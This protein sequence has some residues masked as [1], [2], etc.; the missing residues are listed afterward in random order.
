VEDWVAELERGR[1]DAAWDLFLDRYRRLIFAAIRHYAQDYDDVMDVFARACE[2]LRADNLRR[3]RTYTDQPQHRATFSTWLVT[4]VRH[5]TVDW[6]RHRDGR[7]RLSVVAEG[8]PPIRRRIFEHVFLDQRSHI[9][10]YELI[11]AGEAPGLSFR[12]FLSELRATYHAISA[13]R[14]GQILRDLAP[15]SAEVENL[16][17][18][19]TEPSATGAAE[20]SQ[21]M[22]RALNVLGPDDRMIVEL[23]VLEELSA[24]TVAKVLG[25]ANAKAVYNRAYRALAVVREQ[26]ERAGV[27][28]EDL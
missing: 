6:F 9:E 15:L 17:A 22:E 2:A 24:E 14:R 3:I 27:R 26:L 10:A 13:G 18:D 25:L 16:P 11:H 28:R 12:E 23:F 5:L 21:I 4:V 7:R 20:Q 1:F 8:L 19:P